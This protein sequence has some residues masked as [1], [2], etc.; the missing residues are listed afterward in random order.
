MSGFCGRKSQR[1]W[2]SILIHFVLFSHRQFFQ[3]KT[4]KQSNG[5]AEGRELSQT[6]RLRV[7]SVHS[8]AQNYFCR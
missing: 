2:P 5:G 3:A 8:V 7:S 6:N 1:N 4:V